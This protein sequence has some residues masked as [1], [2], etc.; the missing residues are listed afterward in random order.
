MLVSDG[1][2]AIKNRFTLYEQALL[3]G[4]GFIHGSDNIT[5]MDWHNYVHNLS[6]QESLPGILGIGYINYKLAEDVPAF[7]E[8]VRRDGAPQFVNHPQTSFNDKFIITYIEPQGLNDQALG[9]DIGFESCRRKAAEKAWHSHQPALTC[10]I[11]LVQDSQK[12]PSFLLLVPVY[13]IVNGEEDYSQP[14]GWVYAPFIGKNFLG[15]IAEISRDQLSLAVFDGDTIAPSATIFRSDNSDS[16]P[17][18]FSTLQKTTTLTTAGQQW[19]MVWRPSKGFEPRTSPKIAHA[20]FIC[21]M[22]FSVFISFFVWLI[23]SSSDNVQ[24]QVSLRTRELE[25]ATRAKSDFLARMSHEIRT[26]MNGILGFV[27]ILR[28]TDLTEFQ[29]KKLEKIDIAGRTLLAIINDILDLSKINAGMMRLEHRAFNL[30]DT[31]SICIDL[32]DKEATAKGLDVTFDIAAS[33]PT[34]L[35]GDQYRLQQICLNLLS[36]AVKFTQSG[37]VKLLA[38][39][40][41]NH[42]IIEVIDSGI[43]IAQDKQ[44]DVFIS[45]MQE[46]AGMTRQYGGTGLGLPICKQLVTAMGGTITLESEKGKGTHFTVTVPLEKGAMEKKN[47]QVA[48]SSAE[49]YAILL[50]ED[51]PMNQEITKAMLE[52]YGHKVDVVDNGQ[53]AIDTLRH[54]NYDL[55]LMDIQMPVMDGLATTREIRETLGFGN[56]ELPIIALTAHTMPEDVAAFFEV[57]IDD[58]ILK[59]VNA[60]DLILKIDQVLHDDGLMGTPPIGGAEDRVFDIPLFDQAQYQ[61]LVGILGADKSYDIYKEFYRDAAVRI[62]DLRAGTLERKKIHVHLHSMSSM[63]GNMGFKRMEFECRRLLDVLESMPE[64][65]LAEDMKALEQ[66]YQQGCVAFDQYNGTI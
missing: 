36:N 45:F 43:G 4:R 14:R 15:D 49:T 9:L 31:L 52:R 32:L 40:E 39:Y 21:G 27:D 38:K 56:E 11:E 42:L 28:Q 47:D 20:V 65:V 5:R 61:S 54:K 2:Q 59:P 34:I 30:P 48:L 64:G 26:P 33:C 16:I 51:T 18:E 17:D 41:D 3:G 24:R 25:E 62:K 23:T 6:V 37:F 22:T 53:A 7:L 8:Q 63:A 55:V 10:K 29:S 12:F 13:N 57:G 19:T 46:D 58:Y 60:P 35:V 66:L 1:E 50:V 44:D